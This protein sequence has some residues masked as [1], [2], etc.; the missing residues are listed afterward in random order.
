MNGKIK[1][2]LQELLIEKEYHRTK[3]ANAICKNILDNDTEDYITFNP[4]EDIDRLVDKI[5][6][7]IGE[8]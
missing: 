2:Q 3:L 4:N 5:I 1:K 6:D 8:K 7:L